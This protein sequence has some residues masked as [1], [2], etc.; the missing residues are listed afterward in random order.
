MLLTR[1]IGYATGEFMDIDNKQ[2]TPQAKTISDLLNTIGDDE[3]VARKLDCPVSKPRYWRR[4]NSIPS[5]YFEELS[6]LGLSLEDLAKA[7]A[8]EVGAVVK[9]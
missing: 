9:N 1:K 5:K 4:R 6:R 3:T 8:R 2:K 7:N